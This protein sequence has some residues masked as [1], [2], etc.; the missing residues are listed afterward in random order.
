MRTLW[1]LLLGLGAAGTA[2]PAAA[3]D[4]SKIDRRIGR[5]PAYQFESATLRP[6]RVWPEGR[7][8]RL[9]RH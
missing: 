5:E 1:A 7:I 3:A 9:A 4:L 8:P 6:A 2:E